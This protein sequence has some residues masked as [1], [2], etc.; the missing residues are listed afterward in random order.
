MWAVAWC[1][2]MQLT[3][4]A[5][6]AVRVMIHL[7]TQPPGTRMKRESLAAA[8][9]VPPHFLSKV[10]QSL[11]RARLIVAH[12]GTTG[13]FSLAA[14]ADQVSVLRVV[15]AVEGT[16]QLNACLSGGAGCNR[17]GWCPAHPVWVE[18]QAALT[19]VLKNASIGRLASQA[20]GPRQDRVIYPWN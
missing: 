13:G 18:A 6:Y 5:D 2:H 14:P 15:E 1:S 12:R 10:L 3:R 8:A 17:Q 9:D 11:S 16:L 20:D 19:E 7:A 4:A